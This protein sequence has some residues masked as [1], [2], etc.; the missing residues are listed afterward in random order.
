MQPGVT[1]TVEPAPLHYAARVE[2]RKH[3]F[4]SMIAVAVSVLTVGWLWYVQFVRPRYK[5][6]GPLWE[7]LWEWSLLPGIMTVLLAIAGLHQESRK[8]WLSFVAIAITVLAYLLLSP[9]NNLS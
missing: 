8:R 2:R 1:E 9:P 3:S 6:G 7:A 4:F 5:Q